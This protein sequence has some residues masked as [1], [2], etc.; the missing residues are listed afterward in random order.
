MEGDIKN[1]ILRKHNCDV[2]GHLNTSTTHSN[3]T[4]KYVLLP[5]YYLNYHYKKKSYEVNVNGSTGR[6]LGKSPVSPL[7]VLI[8]IA[9][10][11]AAFFG[12]YY[13]FKGVDSSAVSS[14][15]GLIT[16]LIR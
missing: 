4:Y 13:L 14:I 9:V 11:A 2:V 15:N 16:R 5:I 7:K 6:V 3:V 8:A 10:G 1:A 12:L